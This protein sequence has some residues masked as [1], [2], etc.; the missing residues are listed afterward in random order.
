MFENY[1][2]TGFWSESDYITGNYTGEYPTDEM[3]A[4]AESELGYKLPEAYIW[5]MRNQRNGGVPEK[6]YFHTD[7]GGIFWI[8]GIMGIGSE[9]EYSL[10]GPLG[11]RFWIE[12]WGYPDIGIAICDTPSAGHEMIFLDYR[13]CGP[14]GEP[15][16][17]YI[18]QE[19]AYCT[20]VLADSFEQFILGL[21]DVGY[22]DED[23]ELPSDTA[24]AV[25]SENE[26]T[27]KPGFFR[28][29]FGRK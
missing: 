26:K 3:I 24:A 6:G 14:Q 4:A 7:D 13:E 17:T 23:S 11:S 27:G 16:V 21:T 25:S 20:V 1:D 19:A 5:L 2:F 15:N 9:R 18:D 29:L 10:C 8:N 12:E 22:E 28:R